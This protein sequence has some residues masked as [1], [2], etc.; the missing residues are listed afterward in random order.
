VFDDFTDGVIYFYAA[1]TSDQPPQILSAKYGADSQG[2]FH[3]T[4]TY[5]LSDTGPG[6][7]TA[8]YIYGDLQYIDPVT[9]L[10]NGVGESGGGVADIFV[11][12]PAAVPGPIVGAGLP[13]LILASGGLLGFWRVQR[14]RADARDS[15]V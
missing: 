9:G 7:L 8:V 14:R 12:P 5:T 1:T 10:P 13:G 2:V 11:I 6:P 15:S 4:F 3:A